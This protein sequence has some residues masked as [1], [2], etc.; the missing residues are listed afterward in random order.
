MKYAA[1]VVILAILILIIRGD[2]FSPSPLIIAGQ[3]AAVIIA[4]SARAAFRKQQFRTVAEPGDGPLVRN[5]PYRLIRHPMYASVLLLIW[6]GILGHL[7]V[8]NGIIGAVVTAVVVMRISIE[9]QLLRERYPEYA[10]YARQTKRM[11]PFIY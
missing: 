10:G 3:V 11:I 6:V 7:S 5:G 9:E 4:F 2:F 1:V 8:V